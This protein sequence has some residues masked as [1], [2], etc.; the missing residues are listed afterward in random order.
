M[1]DYQNKPIKN[2]LLATEDTNKGLWGEKLIMNRL[3]N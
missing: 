1:K 2:N 3:E